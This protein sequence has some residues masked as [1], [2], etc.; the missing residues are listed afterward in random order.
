MQWSLGSAPG[1]TGQAPSRTDA[2][3]A[4][5]RRQMVRY[6]PEPEYLSDWP[7]GHDDQ[8]KF[9]SAGGQQSDPDSDTVPSVLE[10]PSNEPEPV[11]AL[12]I[13]PDREARFYLRAKLA[14]AGMLRADEAT[15]GSEALYLLKTRRY[16]LVLMDVDLP[17]MDGWH[18]TR[19]VTAGKHQRA[20][21]DY[22]VLTGQRFS[23]L[24]RLRA[25][26]AGAHSCLTKPLEP[27]ELA[28]LLRRLRP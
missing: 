19:R 6:V 8:G 14:M 22:V 28:S 21:A 23:W 10:W 2:A 17:D 16:H 4:V 7:E 26:F 3:P 5:T 27:G 18:L 12:I 11:N 15:T 24:G 9:A 13:D 1:S 25:R 20:L